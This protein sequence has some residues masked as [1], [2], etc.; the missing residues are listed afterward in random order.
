MK[1]STIRL[2]EALGEIDDCYITEAEHYR[3]PAR[4]PIGRWAT[5]AAALVLITGGLLAFVLTLPQETPPPAPPIPTE[6][7]METASATD[8]ASGTETAASSEE[9]TDALTVP[10]ESDTPPAE[11]ETAAPPPTYDDA[12][13]SATVVD[14]VFSSHKLEGVT[15]AYTTWY[16][17]NLGMLKLPPLPTD[18][19]VPVWRYTAATKPLDRAELEADMAAIYPRLEAMLGVKLPSLTYDSRD[20]ESLSADYELGICRYRISAYQYSGKNDYSTSTAR[21]S[22]GIHKD[23][24]KDTA[25]IL[26]HG[27]PLRVDQRLTDEEILASLAD[28]RDALF[29]A[30]GQ[31]FDSAKVVR[32]YGGYNMEGVERLDIVYYNASD[33][34]G[35]GDCIQ[36]SFDN[37]AN[38]SGDM[39]S[40]TYLEEAGIRYTRYRVPRE[41]TYT[42]EANCRLLSLA[43]A[44]ALLD[45]GYVFGGHVCPLCMAQQTPV[46]FDEYDAVSLIYC[47]GDGGTSGTALSVPF[48]AFYKDIGESK[49]GNR[50]FAR[51]L[52]PAVEV[53]G[54]SEYFEMQ[55][56]NH[57]GGTVEMLP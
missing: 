2:A 47:T 46:S 22:I 37:F 43:E 56:E 10:T 25:P 26:I 44:E 13:L 18:E 23:S 6:T 41:S 11:T 54:L 8:A 24:Y 45:A 48:Y 38:W 14:E 16:A 4:P 15:N 5:V 19:Y 40:A 17:P 36:I 7:D 52:V 33:V 57:V 27:K 32:D 1:K 29:E 51:T 42:V 50:I 12:F 3:A 49:N 9:I 28:I 20:S 55:K 30:F 39:V 35:Q 31:S 34:P 21:M 53:S